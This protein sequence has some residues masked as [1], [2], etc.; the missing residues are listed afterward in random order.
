[1]NA[2]IVS[3]LT[4]NVCLKGS[5]SFTAAPVLLTVDVVRA[6]AYL[7]RERRAVP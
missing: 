6:F 7:S 2:V 4:G 1:M 3:H 5:F